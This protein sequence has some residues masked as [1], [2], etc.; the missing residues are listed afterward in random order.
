MDGNLQ[1]VQLR[2]QGLHLLMDDVQVVLLNYIFNLSNSFLQD[3]YWELAVD[4]EEIYSDQSS[5][6]FKGLSIFCDNAQI[7]QEGFLHTAAF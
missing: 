5:Q 6:P 2:V 7:F 3:S 1:R 4:F